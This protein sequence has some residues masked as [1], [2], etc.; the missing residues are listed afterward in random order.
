MTPFSSFWQAGY[1]GADHINQHGI[2][3]SMNETNGHLLR[4]KEDYAALKAFGITTVRESVGWRLTERDG[5]YDFSSLDARLEAAQEYDI[6][7]CWTLCHYGWPEDLHLFSSDFIPRFAAFCAAA[8]D[9]IAPRSTRTPIYSPNNEISFL[10]WGLSVGL[11]TCS[12]LPEQD[13]ADACKR[14]LIR[15]TLAG[16]DAIWEV[17]SKARI[18]HC[19]P[20][21]HIVATEA[22][23]EARDAAQSLSNAQFQAWDMLRGTLAPELGGAP[24]YLDLIGA[25]YYHDNQWEMPSMARLHWHLGDRRRK[26]LHTMLEELQQR[27]QRPMVISETS[28][29]GSG[30]GAWIADVTAQVAQA[31]LAGVELYGVCLYPI[32]DRP[33]WNDLTAWPHSGLWDLDRNG[34]DPFLRLINQ[35]YAKALSQAQRTLRHFQSFTPPAA[36]NKENGMQ[37]KTLIVFSHLRWGFVFQRPQHLLSRLAQHYRV[38][39]IEEPIYDAQAASLHYSTPAPN[40]TVI[41][42]HTPIAAPGFHDDQIATLQL[43]LTELVDEQEQPVVWFYTPMAL[44]LLTPFTPSLVIYDCMDELSAFNQAPRQLQQRESALMTRADLV[45]TGGSSLY[46][47][48][49]NKHHA[50]Y[51]FPSSVDAVHFEQALDRSNGHPLQQ[52]LPPMRL[53][54]YGVIDE[55]LDIDLVAAL[56]DTHPEWQIVMVGPVVKIDPA[57]LPQRPNIHWLGQQPYEAL[58]QFLAGWD[59]CLMPFALNASTQF[60]SPTKVLEYMAAQLPIV[61]TA[62]ADIVRHYPDLVAIAYS[63][64]EFVRA[65]ERALA[66]SAEE[67]EMKAQQM[68]AVVAATSWDTTTEQMHKL[69]SQGAAA[70]RAPVVQTPPVIADEVQQITRRLKP[71]AD[72]LSSLPCLIIGAGPTGLSAGYHYGKGALVLEKNA[73]PGGWC[74]SLNDKGFTFDYAGHI[75]FS[76]DPYVLKLYE[77]LLGD[78][79]HWQMREAWVYNDGGTYTRYPFQGSLHGLPPEVIKECILGAIE[80]RYGVA[81]DAAETASTAALAQ[82]RDCC[83]DGV[84]PDGECVMQEKGQTENFEQFIYK[85]WGRGIAKHFAVPYNKKLWTLPLSEM[86]TSWLG[87][88]VPLPDLAQIVEGALAPLEKPMGPNAR[89]GYPLKGGFQALMHGFLPHLT[90]ELETNSTLAALHPEQH[91]AVLTDGRRY[92]YDQLISTMPL[93]QLIKLIGDE[94]PQEIHDAAAK[95]LHVSIRCVNIGVGRADLTE[96]HWIYYPGETL[97]HRI[98]VQGNA[99]PF[100]NP[101]GGCGLTCEISY[102]PH[103]PLPVDGDALI[104]RCIQECIAVG[105]INADDPI[106]TANQV[107]IP[108]AYVVYDHARQANIALIRDWLLQQDILLSGRYSEWEYYN[109]DHAFLAGKR[110]AEFVKARETTLDKQETGY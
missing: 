61:S 17:D 64:E 75:M 69:M 30:R 104:Q 35:P 99:S 66:M 106:I 29:V 110:A 67:R 23:P 47:A 19:D 54:Y 7:I 57:T 84:V 79:L 96:K 33:G 81:G 83:A 27:Y 22:S 60:I 65:C 48:K 95:L 82:H 39:F 93:P 62:I 56:A 50:I 2:R 44:P 51:C 89:F 49:K 21:I 52:A 45:F 9:Y 87:G 92:R 78:N 80:A 11:F 107:D 94:A 76:Q 90:C 15:A 31:L 36:E 71:T 41:Q 105:M 8:A 18:M 13:P 85:T 38:L 43:L 10:S 58:P 86:E 72:Q 32:I 88:R 100:C 77:M 4:I 91:I 98:F 63:P 59:V 37:Q 68:Q 12:N 42:P 109:S 73:S 53:G 102:S 40:I 26:P 101:P 28:H 14:Q 55:R 5:R 25:N 1:E 108:Y 97:F 20:L 3:L 16:C 103:K 70:A 46:E 6:Q 24:R 34:S 74:R